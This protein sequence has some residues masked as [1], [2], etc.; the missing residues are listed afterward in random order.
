MQ[1]YKSKYKKQKADTTTQNWLF[2]N[3]LLLDFQLESHS[4][5][6]SQPLRYSL[7]LCYSQFSSQTQWNQ[8]NSIRNNHLIW[9]SVSL[10]DFDSRDSFIILYLKNIYFSW[11][12]LDKTLYILASYK[13]YSIINLIYIFYLL[14]LVIQ[15]CR[16]FIILFLTW[17]ISDS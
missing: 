17:L 5:F 7:L 12:K 4:K 10:R 2:Q 11:K 9:P 13:V 3:V 15:K 6:L 14:L 16:C 8:M 1:K